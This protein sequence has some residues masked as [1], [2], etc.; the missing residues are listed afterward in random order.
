MIKTTLVSALCGIFLALALIQTAFYKYNIK[1]NDLK[2]SS[3]N[4]IYTTKDFEP[5]Y[6]PDEVRQMDYFSTLDIEGSYGL[7]IKNLMTGESHEQDADRVFYAASLFKIPVAVGVLRAVEAGELSFDTV[8]EY[9][10]EDFFG[11]TGSV[12]NTDYGTKYTVAEL[13]DRLLKESDNAAQSMLT[14]VTAERHM[15][16]A[17]HSVGKPQIV[18]FKENRATPREVGTML[19]KIYKQELLNSEN[20][21]LILKIMS[22][23]SFD[24]RINSGLE[25]SRTFTHKIG[26]WGETGSWHDCGIIL[27]PEPIVV[28]LMSEGTSFEEFVSVSTLI[29]KTL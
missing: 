12:V 9:K 22:E 5:F 1:K 8:V 28:C 21:K 4:V 18:F 11:G 3:T 7:Y 19:E 27:Y 24:D 6:Q 20:S 25:P 17:F 10:E 26:N 29:G 23:T 13:L 15:A 16:Y 2:V 14:R